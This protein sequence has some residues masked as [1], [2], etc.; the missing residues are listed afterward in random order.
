MSNLDET[1][2]SFLGST[3][4]ALDDEDYPEFLRNCQEDFSYQ[5]TAYSDE[6]GMDM[7]WM[8]HDRQGFE[9]LL[10]MLPKHIRMMGRFSRQA[11][12]SKIV[13]DNGNVQVVSHLCVFH[14]NLDGDTRLL[15]VG[16][17]IDQLVPRDGKPP[18]LARRVVRLDT[19]NLGQGIHVPI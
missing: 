9:G 7:V 10:K 19:R 11:S 18:L 16:R 3:C 12:P 1:V 17:Y 5:V 15:L 14:T 2:R 13:L 6:L 8:E 4:L